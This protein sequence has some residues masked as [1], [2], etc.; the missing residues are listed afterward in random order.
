MMMLSDYPRN[1]W[2]E[3]AGRCESCWAAPEVQ[4]A[5]VRKKENMGD[6][7]FRLVHLEDCPERYNF[8]GEE[9]SGEEPDIAGWEW[10]PNAVTLPNGKSYNV[11]S[12]RA[13]V[14]P[15]V[16]C[17]KLIHGVPL[18]LFGEKGRWEA[19]FCWDCATKDGITKL[20]MT[21]SEKMK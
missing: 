10:Y 12:A 9:I 17:G 15:C 20:L 2:F 19:D 4:I 3:A 13:N 16:A 21:V 1:T 18:I 8:E 11:L 5:F 6:V 7:C 14:G